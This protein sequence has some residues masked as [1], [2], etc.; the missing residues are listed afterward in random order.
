MKTIVLKTLLIS[1][2]AVLF[3]FQAFPQRGVV[4]GS[5][6][7]KG[8]DS[9]TCIRNL[10]LYYEFYKH[11]NFTDAINPWRDIYSDCPASRESLYAN[12]VNMYK[13][14]IE[15][16]KDPLKKAALC[17]TIM[18]IYDQRIKYFGGEGSV[19]GRKG[20]DLLRY[21][22]DD[23][24]S[25]IQEGYNYLKKSVEIE[26]GKSSPVVL[27]TLVSASITLYTRS[28]L[29]NEQLVMD[30]LTASEYLENELAVRPSTKTQ[31]AKDAIDV[32]IRESK[33]LS[34]NVIVSIFEPKFAASQNDPEF[35]KKV[36]GFLSDSQCEGEKLF[37]DASEKLYSVEPSSVA[38][39]KLARVF[40]NRKDFVKSAKYYK[41]AADLSVSADE[42]AGYYYEL[43]IL[44]N[45]EMSQPESAA[46]YLYDAIKIKPNWGDAY[47]LLGSVYG[48]STSIFDN[49]F[50]KKTVYWLA[51]D[52]F[53]KA[54]S[55][56]PSVSEK[57]NSLIT[58]YSAYFPSVEDV[59][60]NSLQ[61]GQSFNIGGWINRST[62][63]RGRK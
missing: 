49:P 30:Y 5:L 1:L 29:S 34:C 55:V 25:F 18:M 3:A 57:A 8:E 7:G 28:L 56:D 63:V 37:A 33:A 17:D 2:I 54:K 44:L 51:V 59:F 27:T 41:E 35:L 50:M 10:S 47:I 9:I 52:M 19:L 26:K 42:K 43:A 22:R 23:G 46:T 12:G 21:R 62:T 32:N 13:A 4:D 20:V 11:D 31:Q 48:S 6:Y 58:N 61:E 40:F 39:Y 38:A 16:E 14:F 15:A 53:Q 60:F 24:S 36:T 45:N